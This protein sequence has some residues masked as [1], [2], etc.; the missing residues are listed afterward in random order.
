MVRIGPCLAPSPT[1]GHP[2]PAW[3]TIWERDSVFVQS[4]SQCCKLIGA[5]TCGDKRRTAARMIAR[6]GAA[7]ISLTE[8]P[9][10]IPDTTASTV[11]E[12]G[13]KLTLSNTYRSD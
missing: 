6:G 13:L 8:A 3:Q 4:G 5:I 10:G 11:I 12:F 1:T 7:M 2:Q 9:D